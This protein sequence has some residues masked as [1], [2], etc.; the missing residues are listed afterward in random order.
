VLGVDT[1]GP[2]FSRVTIRP[3]LSLL[4]EVSGLIPHPK[5]EISVSLKLAQGKLIAEV[6]LPAGVTGE[7]EWRGSKRALPSGKFRLEF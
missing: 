1:A 7:F 6:S 3:H 5:G 4:T 2:G